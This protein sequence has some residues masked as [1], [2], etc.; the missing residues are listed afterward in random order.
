MAASKWWLALVLTVLPVVVLWH[1]AGALRDRRAADHR[2]ALLQR[3][4]DLAFAWRK[5]TDLAYWV[6]RRARELQAQL[7]RPARTEVHI[8]PFRPGRSLRSARSGAE[9]GRLELEAGTA[10]VTPPPPGLA[11]PA[12][13]SVLAG[14]FASATSAL[15]LQ[16]LP[17]PVVWA[18]AAPE[19]G[20]LAG[21]H[22]A[23]AGRPLLA[24]LL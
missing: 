10:S 8:A 22:L 3:A 18:M 15:C 19:A 9:P 5:R 4:Q 17:P 13:P 21:G 7:D 11:S 20:L 12:L 24:P 2:Q 6:E 16:G 23:S 14:R 1:E